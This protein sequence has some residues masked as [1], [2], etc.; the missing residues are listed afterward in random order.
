M[1]DRIAIA[2]SERRGLESPVDAR[3]GR[4]PAFVIVDA[5]TG[6][7]H[8]QLENSAASGAHGAGTGAAALV[9]GEAV[10][11]VLAGEFG[12]KATEALGRLGI[13]MWRA[14]AGSTV[15]EA[16]ARWSRGELQVHELA[17]FR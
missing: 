10:H 3:F 14:P 4:A 12:P 11:A 16:F 1:A 13:K 15:S 6:E 17:V 8:S 5:A 7:L 9:A 2:A